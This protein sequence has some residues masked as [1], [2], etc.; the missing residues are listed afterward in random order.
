MIQWDEKLL[1]S[2]KAYNR[3]DH[4]AVLA[5]ATNAKVMKLFGTTDLHNGTGLNQAMAIKDILEEWN[6]VKQCVAT[7]FDTTASNTR[8]FTGACILM[9]AFIAA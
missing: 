8:K 1:K 7:C 4:L 3:K 5:S 6:I 9:E 2:G